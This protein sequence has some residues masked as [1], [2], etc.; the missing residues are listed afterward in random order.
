MVWLHGKTKAD[1]NGFQTGQIS[2]MVKASNYEER[3][4]LVFAPQC[5]QPY[6]GSGG[7]WDD[8]PGEEALDLLDELIEELP[9]IDPNRIYVVG[10]S[11][12]GFGAWHFMKEEPRLFAAGIAIA[13]ASSGVSKLRSVP[14]WL[15][16]GDKDEAVDVQGSRDAAEELKR[17]KVFKYTEFPGEGH[18]ILGKVLN[19]EK[20]H[21]WLF[22]QIKK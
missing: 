4:C 1:E 13:G 17:S 9:L 11:M 16:H 20:T 2:S 8:A 3:P 15:F 19:D 22:S 6:G 14:I 12:G 10:Y 7:G 21:K 5:Y 18:G